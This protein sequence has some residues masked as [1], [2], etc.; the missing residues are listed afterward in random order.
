MSWIAIRKLKSVRCAPTA[1][2][3]GSAALFFEDA[4]RTL[5]LADEQSSDRRD[6]ARASR[7]FSCSA[8]GAILEVGCGEGGNLANLGRRPQGGE[9]RRRHGPVRAKGRLRSASRRDGYFVARVN[10]RCHSRMGRSMPGCAAISFTISTSAAP[11]SRSCAGSASRRRPLDLEEW[12]QPA[13]MILAAIRTARTGPTPQSTDRLGTLVAE[14]FAGP[15]SRYASD[16]D[17]RL[18]LHQKF[19]LPR[20]GQSRVARSLMPV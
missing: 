7:R 20:L 13:Q 16:A 11:Q 5:S 15:G 4:E 6:R 10:S 3:S 14:H 19:G 2:G 18:V 1:T 9:A 12:A 8:G 17:H